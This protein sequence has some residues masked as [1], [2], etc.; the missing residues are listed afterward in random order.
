MLDHCIIVSELELPIWGELLS[1][2]TCLQ[3]KYSETC[4]KIQKLVQKGKDGVRRYVLGSAGNDDNA[5]LFS[6]EW[7]HEVEK[8][9]VPDMIDCESGFDLVLSVAE[10]EDLQ[11]SIENKGF[12]RWITLFGVVCGEGTD[13]G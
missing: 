11:T 5:C 3:S 7:A 1:L 12:D 4:L 8:Q 2:G 9:S 13:F 6:K 10:I